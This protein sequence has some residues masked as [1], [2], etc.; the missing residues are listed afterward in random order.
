MFIDNINESIHIIKLKAQL[1]EEVD[2]I[3]A[4]IITRKCNKFIRGSC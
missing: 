4:H 3:F 1:S 2:I